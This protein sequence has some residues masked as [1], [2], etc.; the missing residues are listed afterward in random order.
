MDVDEVM[1]NGVPSG[2]TC[3]NAWAMVSQF[4]PSCPGPL[5]EQCPVTCGTCPETSSSDTTEM[6]SGNHFCFFIIPS[7]ILDGSFSL[8]A[9][10]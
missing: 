5:A 6:P 3:E 9:K 8:L 2:R 4:M 7:P 1:D 10:A